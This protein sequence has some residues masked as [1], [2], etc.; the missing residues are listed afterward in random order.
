VLVDS[1]V[2]PGKKEKPVEQKEKEPADEIAVPEKKSRTKPA[3]AATKKTSA[4]PKT[5]AGK[6][7]ADSAVK[8][9]AAIPV[10]KLDLG[11]RATAALVDAGLK[12]VSQVAK[13]LEAGEEKLLAVPGVGAKTVEDIKKKLKKMGIS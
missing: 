7:S 13:K 4:K 11:A 3:A 8:K 6:K 12:T 9:P 10:E 1:I 5:Q 2:F